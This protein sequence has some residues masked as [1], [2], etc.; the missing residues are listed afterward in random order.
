MR[1]IK[2]HNIFMRQSFLVHKNTFVCMYIIL[3][4]SLFSVFETG[5]SKHDILKMKSSFDPTYSC[6]CGETNF[7]YCYL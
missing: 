1:I 4:I 6:C 5:D 2:P 3:I 7:F